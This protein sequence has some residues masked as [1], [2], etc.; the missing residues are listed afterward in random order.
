[1]DDIA[2]RESEGGVGGSA[3]NPKADILRTSIEQTNANAAEPVKATPTKGHEE[4]GTVPRHAHFATPV[5]M[6]VREDRNECHSS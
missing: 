4:D 1:M 5:N 6:A 3:I 2:T